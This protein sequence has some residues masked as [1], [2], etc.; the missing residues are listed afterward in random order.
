M[1]AEEGVQTYMAALDRVHQEQVTQR[2]HLSAWCVSVH[3]DLLPAAFAGLSVVAFVHQTH[4]R[5]GILSIRWAG[6]QPGPTCITA[7]SFACSS[8]AGLHIALARA[9]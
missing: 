7:Y 6:I 3:R 9:S 5:H 1:G 8:D 4:R 2:V